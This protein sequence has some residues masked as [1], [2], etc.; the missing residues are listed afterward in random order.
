MECF[1]YL[2]SFEEV[3][4]LVSEIQNRLSYFRGFQEYY[5][6]QVSSTF[7]IRPSLSRTITDLYKLEKLEKEIF[8]DFK[9]E[10]VVNKLE[11]S[12]IL[13]PST[14]GLFKDDWY[15]LAQAQ[16]CGLPTRLLDFA[17]KWEVALYFAVEDSERYNDDDG[18]FW[19]FSPPQSMILN[20][21]RKREFLDLDPIQFKSQ[22]L[23]NPAF[24]WTGNYEKETAEMRRARQHGKFFIQSL[25]DSVIPME[26]QPQLSPLL[27]KY[28]IPKH[29]KSK[30]REQ[31][32]DRGFT[33]EFLYPVLTPE[34]KSIVKR[35]R[36]KY[37]V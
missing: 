26:N 18:Q 21:S 5:R 23:I 24:F 7:E 19:V 32:F 16:H 8:Q 14:T 25:S 20:D 37:C 28:C 3:N 31:L 12:F 10:I 13:N 2:T 30:I 6:G 1:K 35:L 17:L 15:L 22:N 34:L 11:E 4:D 9:N 33:K 36:E 29:A 27:E